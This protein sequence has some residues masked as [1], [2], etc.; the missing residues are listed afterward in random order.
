MSLSYIDHSIYNY[1]NRIVQHL[2]NKVISYHRE[3]YDDTINSRET[4]HTDTNKIV[5]VILKNEFNLF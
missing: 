1:S 4:L 5:E 2:N 3:Q